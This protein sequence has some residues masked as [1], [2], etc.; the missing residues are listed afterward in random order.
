M[1]D[2]I[3][4]PIDLN[5][6]NQV[7][8]IFKDAAAKIA[9]KNVNH[10]QYWNDP[11]EHKLEWLKQG[12]TDGEYNF[13]YHDSVHIGMVRILKSDKLYW[14][15][16][17]DGNALYVH[18]LVIFEQF[19]GKGYGKKV[20]DHIANLAAV[21]G[22]QYLRLDADVANPRLCDYYGNLG[23]K[24]VGLVKQEISSYRLF[25]REV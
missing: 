20:L 12:L 2:L 24:E 15:D 1:S 10:W 19:N 7:L 14:G 9:K 21:K 22:K 11:P 4:K 13:I 3:L 18:S 16:M 8:Q 17:D 6:Y 25:E 23:F 5:H